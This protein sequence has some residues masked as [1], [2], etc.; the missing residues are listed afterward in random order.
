M[1]AKK[2]VLLLDAIIIVILTMAMLSGTAITKTGLNAKNKMLADNSDLSFNLIASPEETR[3]KAGATVEITLSAEDIKIGKEGLNSIVGYLSYDEGLFD[4]VEIKAEEEKGWN[5]ELNKIKG[6]SMYGKFCI[7]TMQE[8]VTENQNVVKMK[9]KLKDDLKPQTTKVYFTE[10]ASS[11]GE[12]EVPEEDRVVT[13]IIYEDGVP[14]KEK[15]DEPKPVKT[16]DNRILVVIAIAILTIILNILT[17][18][19]NKKAKVLGTI[20]VAVL[21][22]SSLGIVT[23][24]AE[25]QINVAEVLNRLSYRESWLNSEKYLVT[26]ENV[27]RVAPGTKVEAIKSQFNKEIVVTQNGEEVKDGT[28]LGTGM[29]VSVKNPSKVDAEG[30]YAYELSVYGD[31]NGDGKSNQVELTRIIRNVVDAEKWNLT[32][33]KKISADLTV[34]NKIDEKDVNPSVKYIVYGEMEIPEFDQVEEPTIEVVEGTFDEEDNCYTT[35]VKVKITEKAENG[36][37]TQYKVENSKGMVTPYTEISREETEDGKIETIIELE[38]DEIYKVSAY[39]TGELGNRSGIPYIIVNGVYNNIRKYTVEYYYRNLENEETDTYVKDEEK[40]EEKYVEIGTEITT[41]VEKNKPGYEKATDKGTNGVEGLPLTVKKNEKENVIKVYYKLHHYSI[42][43]DPN[44]GTWPNGENP[45]PGEYTI[46][47]PTITVIDPGRVGYEITGWTEEDGQT[48]VKPYKIQTG[49]TGDIT[50]K[51]QW[52]ELEYPIQ[53]TETKNSTVVDNQVNPIKYLTSETPINIFNLNNVEGFNFKG[54]KLISV[55]GESYDGTT[56]L[57]TKI[58]E[59]QRGALVFEGQWEEAQ[60]EPHTVTAEVVGGHGTIAPESQTVENDG[61]VSNLV[62]TADDNYIVDI[63]RVYPGPKDPNKTYNPK[64]DTDMPRVRAKKINGIIV[65]EEIKNITEDKHVVAILK[66]RNMNVVA[67]I[68]AVPSDDQRLAT[69]PSDI[70]GEDILDHEY[71]TLEDALA[72]AL[73]TNRE[74]DNLELTGKVEIQIIADIEDEANEIIRTGN[75]GKIN[76]VIIDL[77]GFTVKNEDAEKPTIRVK[78]DASLQIVDRSVGENGKV[79]NAQGIGI[80]VEVGGE[81]T[82]GE[83]DGLTKVS[84]TA[85]VVSGGTYGVYKNTGN[86]EEG[87]FNFYDGKIIGNTT[88]TLESPASTGGGIIINTPIVYNA[89]D[90]EVVVEDI[91]TVEKTLQIDADTEAVIGTT[92]YNQVQQAF[93]DINDGRY[94]NGNEPVLVTLVKDATIDPLEMD[95]EQIIVNEGKKVIFDLNGYKI[96][97]TAS[98]ALIN[99]SGELEIIDNTADVEEKIKGELKKY[100]EN[101]EYYFVKNGNYIEPN[102]A[103]KNKTALGY[104]EIDLTEKN[105]TDKYKLTVSGDSNVPAS[106][107]ITDSEEIPESY[108]ILSEYLKTFE[109][110]ELVGGKKYYIHLKCTANTK[111]GQTVLLNQVK[112]TDKNTNEKINLLDNLIKTKGVISCEINNS[113]CIKN[114][115]TGKLKLRNITIGNV[116]SSS[117]AIHNAG[118]VEIN[119]CRVVGFFTNAAENTDENKITIKDSYIGKGSRLDYNVARTKRSKIEVE[120]VTSIGNIYVNS[121]FE[122][123]NLRAITPICIGYENADENSV[124]NAIIKNS[125]IRGGSSFYSGR[126]VYATAIKVEKNAIVTLE[127][128][129]IIEH[130]A[131]T[132]IGNINIIESNIDGVVNSTIETS[133]LHAEDSYIRGIENSGNASLNN[134]TAPEGVLNSGNIR[135]EEGTYGFYSYTGQG[136][137]PRDG[138]S[139]FNTGNA[140]IVSGT[141]NGKSAGVCL[142]RK[143]KTVDGEFQTI[144]ATLVLGVKNTAENKEVSTTTPEIKS[145]EGAGIKVLDINYEF[146]FYDGKVIGKKGNAILCEIEEIEEKNADN[147]SLSLIVNKITENEVEYDEVTLGV[148]SRVAQIKDTYNLNLNGINYTQENGY[149]I[150]NSIQD[151]INACTDNTNTEIEVLKDVSVL[152]INVPQGKDVI[153]DL[154]GHEIST[155]KS[156]QNNGKLEIKDSAEGN[157]GTIKGI[158]KTIYNNENG[159]LK[160][161]GGNLIAQEVDVTEGAHGYTTML[162]NEGTV[163]VDGFEYNGDSKIYNYGT[164]SILNG[165][166]QDIYNNETA[167]INVNGDNTDV[168]SIISRDEACVN[169]SD[170]SILIFKT[171]S[172]ADNCGLNIINGEIFEFTQEVDKEISINQDQGKEIKIT[173]FNS[174]TDYTEKV[175]LNNISYIGYIKCGNLEARNTIFGDIKEYVTNNKSLI[176]GKAEL[177]DCTTS[178]MTV[179]AGSIIKGTAQNINNTESIINGDIDVT[180]SGEVLIENSKVNNACLANKGTGTLTIDKVNI[181]NSNRKAVENTAAG[182]V[183]ITSNTN[184]IFESGES[185]AINNTGSGTIVLGENDSTIKTYPQITGGAVCLANSSNGKIEYYDGKLIAKVKSN[186]SDDPKAYN[187]TGVMTYAEGAFPVKE[188]STETQGAIEYKVETMTLQ[189]VNMAKISKNDVLPA[190]LEGLSYT[191]TDNY[192]EF[193]TVKDAINACTDNVNTTIYLIHD[194]ILS[195]EN[196]INENKK[197]KLDVNGYNLSLSAENAINNSG[198]LEI[199]DSSEEPKAIV[200]AEA[201]SINNDGTIKLNNI[202]INYTKQGTAITDFATGI[203][204]SGTLTIIG[205]YDSSSETNVVEY[206]IN[207][208]YQV[209][210]QNNEGGIVTVNNLNTASNVPT[211]YRYNTN[212]V[213]KSYFVRNSGEYTINNSKIY[214]ENI[215]NDNPGT[216]ELSNSKFAGAIVN[217]S[218]KEYVQGTSKPAIRINNCKLNIATG[219]TSMA[220]GNIE[221]SNHGIINLAG[222][223]IIEGQNTTAEIFIEVYDPQDKLVG[224]TNKGKLKI[225]NGTYYATI[226][227]E[228]EGTVVHENGTVYGG[229]SNKGTYT[230]LDGTYSEGENLSTRGRFFTGIFNEENAVLTIGNKDGSINNTPIIY[231]PDTKNGPETTR[232]DNKGTINFY[233][234]EITVKLEETLRYTLQGE[235]N[236][237]PD[238]TSMVFSDTEN[239]RIYT[240]DN[241]GVAQIGTTK[242]TTLK[243]AF[244]ACTT[245]NQTTIDVLKNIELSKNDMIEI[246]ENQNIKLNLNGKIIVSNVEDFA[247]KVLGTFEVTDSTGNGAMYSRAIFSSWGVTSVAQTNN[248]I[249]VK[250]NLT[251]SGGKVY[252]YVEVPKLSN[253]D[254]QNNITPTV[255]LTNGYVS[256]LVNAIQNNTFEFYRNAR[257]V[258]INITDSAQA[259]YVELYGAVNAVINGEN[260]RIREVLV[261]TKG[262]SPLTGLTNGVRIIKDENITTVKNYGVLYVEGGTIC[263]IEQEQYYTSTNRLYISNNSIIGKIYDYYSEIPRGYIEIKDSII[264]SNIELKAGSEVKLLENVIVNPDEGVISDEI[265]NKLQYSNTQANEG[266]KGGTVTMGEKDYNMQKDT[267]KIYGKTYGLSGCALK[268]YDGTIYGTTNALNSNVTITDLEM[269]YQRYSE[270]DGKVTYL[271]PIGNI[272]DA[273]GIDNAGTFETL[274]LALNSI[275]N[276]ADKT[277]TIDLINKNTTIGSASDKITIKSGMNVTIKL[278]GYSITGAL[279]DSPVIEVESGA[280]LTIIDTLGGKVENTAG[281]AIQNNGT[282]NLGVSGNTVNNQAFSIKGETNAISNAGTLNFYNGI[283][284]A[285]QT[286]ITGT[287]ISAHAAGYTVQDGTIVI[288][289][290]TYNTKYLQK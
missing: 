203:I 68:V 59:G 222:E 17:F 258:N 185:N 92:K 175:I 285:K 197:I 162:Y 234:G 14:E 256:K 88:G 119:D 45:N 116:E 30:N 125:E 154:K 195:S 282:L 281:I 130:A 163:I 108:D 142:Q 191:E 78:S 60:P 241:E 83:D 57:E 205:S 86:G 276:K 247:F 170:G 90:E 235:I 202:K 69:L 198:N 252:G 280:T 77:N 186:S 115:A 25:G 75:T 156:L 277:G 278:N 110:D 104:I 172:N 34:D 253:E 179:G 216:I 72:D 167:T 243:K 176:S 109:E 266:I 155:H 183:I 113:N 33:V 8:G 7:Y 255:N 67:K 242:Y 272:N 160:L 10:L 229:I 217:N 269:Y 126:E 147:E 236:D 181:N 61:S 188:Q 135:I 223:M 144:P 287:A 46:E 131:V 2:L 132:N 81:L 284:E 117:N 103:H 28:V 279:S 38:K 244:E 79:V 224:I 123:N 31:T 124:V 289:G 82:L 182:T 262:E 286:V 32:G 35:N 225:K 98:G 49:K 134:I 76:E 54:W 84:Q 11:D 129:N 94:D 106:I 19:K 177:T 263:Q 196:K 208:N 114:E 174:S 173:R 230:I 151:A 227:N 37:K 121:D 140:E 137:T 21:G 127:K 16:V 23:Y 213:S 233:D 138:V 190:N 100:N 4:S 246:T 141:F 259:E 231:Y 95:P 221:Y 99:N 209:L 97:G 274:A 64:T 47:T 228:V 96:N 65:L 85:P 275:Y 219:G 66:E 15:K 87:I 283:I 139:L 257:N 74:R 44:G 27:S 212:D 215:Y 180:G 58:A 270:N 171:S 199:I 237:I 146:K 149:Y 214:G 210:I 150:F 133:E 218:Q 112:L 187:E 70:D 251:V 62:I 136:T 29:K 52:N 153:L 145:S 3:V 122:A 260:V 43:Y 220:G 226:G 91:T 161:S 39:T 271:T 48:P 36:I 18:A 204:N 152:N 184:N 93:K 164:M 143:L 290:V 157:T 40:T 1:K 178:G 71:E 201:E 192:Y 267:I 53:Y 232:I 12:V 63:A 288:D 248:L 128:T 158:K 193:L 102:N 268:L 55:A 250:G 169:V 245:S 9:M 80:Q 239:K 166:L 89:H 194:C 101:D 50:I 105:E 6:H 56:S 51:A 120:N 107:K 207:K 240:L 265:R 249:Q 73:K 148:D 42:T 5:I 238:N 211:Q 200:I 41:Y 22:L 206:Q 26:A 159:T 189:V 264:V 13:I 24:A 165:K 273:A 261:N 168:H 118:K 254:V 111:T 20:L